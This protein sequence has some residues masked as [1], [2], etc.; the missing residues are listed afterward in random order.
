MQALMYMVCSNIAQLAYLNA[1]HYDITRVFFSGGFVRNNPLLWNKLSTSIDY[2]SKG[3]MRVRVTSLHLLHHLCLTLCRWS[4]RRR[5]SFCTTDISA[6][7]ARCCLARRLRRRHHLRR[8]RLKQRRAHHRRRRHHRRRNI[9][10]TTPPTL[11]L[12]VN[13]DPMLYIAI[14][15]TIFHSPISTVIVTF[16]FRSFFRLP[17]ARFQ[18]RSRRRGSESEAHPGRGSTR[19]CWER[20]WLHSE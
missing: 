12:D 15:P 8:T 20:P 14:S 13:H 19:T 16:I 2:W 9:S 17:Q 4:C 11:Y 1:K 6:P 7:W 10:L 5:T 3:N 18:L